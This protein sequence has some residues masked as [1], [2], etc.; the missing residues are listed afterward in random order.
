MICRLRTDHNPRCV[1]RGVA[2]QPLQPLTHIDQLV[3]LFVALIELA[4]LCIH[5]KR[6]VDRHIQLVRDHFCNG[7]HEGI[8]QIHDAPDVADDTLCRQ[9][10]ERDNLHNLFFSIFASDII[11][12]LLPA[13]IA[14]VDIDIRHGNSFRVQETLKQQVIADRIDIRDMQTVGNDAS[15]CASTSRAYRN[16]VF[17]GIVDKIPH[18]QEIVH[19]SHAFD[20][21][22]LVF[23]TLLQRTVVLRIALFHAVGTQLIQ[24]SP[25]IIA[26]R[27]IKM[28]QLRLPELDFHMAPIRDPLCIFHCLPRIRKQSL[29][30]FFAF[31][32]ILAA[33]IAH[34]VFIR[35]L[36]AGLYTQKNIVGLCILCISIV[37]I[38]RAD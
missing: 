21:A 9:R 10:T 7:I 31:D 25:G 20:N 16:T 34:P 26:L 19:I 8:R 14:E 24:I 15:S 23:Q 27:H 5:R 13:F 18:D 11:D 28:R 38:V 17:S 2:R 37:H 22:Q 36:F 1:H 6:F 4:Q 30:L 29:H 33:L 3:H 12:D 32:E 35:K